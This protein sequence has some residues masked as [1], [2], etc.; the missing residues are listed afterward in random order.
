MTAS[1]NKVHGVGA[2]MV[3]NLEQNT[4]YMKSYQ[5]LYRKRMLRGLKVS[6]LVCKCAFYRLEH[7]AKREP[8]ELNFEDLQMQK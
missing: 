6:S 4:L 8:L 7:N 5:I 2:K 3:L 1:C